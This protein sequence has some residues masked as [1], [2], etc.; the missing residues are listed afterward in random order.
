[1]KVDFSK[2]GQEVPVNLKKGDILRSLLD[3]VEQVDFTVLVFPEAA[4]LREKAKN[5]KDATEREAAEKK[6]AT[7][8]VSERRKYVVIIEELIRIAKANNWG[9]AKNDIYVYLFNG[10]YWEVL[11]EDT[12]SD[13]LGSVAERMG[14][15]RYDARQFQVREYLL[16][17]FLSTSFMPMPDPG[18]EVKI[19]LLNGTFVFGDKRELRPPC[20]EDF[21]KY[22]LPFGYDPA[23]ECPI[24]DQYIERVLPD[25]KARQVLAEYIAY[26]FTKDLKLEKALFLYGSGANGKSVFF[27]VITA[28]LGC[29]NVSTYDINNLTDESGYYRAMFANK[30]INYSSEK[31]RRDYDGDT[32][33]KLCSG[34]PL[35]ARLPYG[36]PFVVSNYAKLIFNANR[37]PA[38]QELTEAFFRRFLIIP[39][40]VTI[41]TKER[42]PDLP[43]MIIKNELSGVFNWVLGGMERILKNRRFTDCEA[44][45]REIDRYRRD[46]DSVCT[47]L[48]E[49]NWAKSINDRTELKVLFAE[50]RQFCGDNNYRSCGN[51]E[52]TRR[53]DLL[54]I[55]VKRSNGTRYVYVSR[56]SENVF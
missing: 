14:L 16:K 42:N 21:I 43:S 5:A 41:P 25:T 37:L 7:M 3:M 2:W 27:D 35:G 20:R 51:K 19:N 52:F 8:K 24:F 50:Y 54:G 32:F 48:D 44:I 1:M 23:A 30:L 9:L 4:A 28:L 17:Q 31:G 39:F 56:H 26:A 34:E 15:A 36:R 45:D 33:K 29:E 38:A 18:N 12:L 10:G 55:E 46:S 40:S 47:F 6:L 13:F 22:R 53:L 49:E 11:E